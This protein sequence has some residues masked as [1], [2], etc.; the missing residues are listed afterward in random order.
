MARSRGPIGA[1]VDALVEA[2]T[3]ELVALAPSR[4]AAAL[5][6]DVGHDAAQLVGALIDADGLHT[7]DELTAYLAAL[8]PHVESLRDATPADLR[9]GALLAGK[10]AWLQTPSTL[11]DLLVAADA[12][13]ATTRS[14]TY[15]RHALELAHAVASIDLVP[16]EHELDAIDRYRTTLLQAMDR[17]GVRRPGAAA[18]AAAVP[19]PATPSPPV[20][21]TPTK[22]LDELLAE[23]DALVGLREVKAEV[24]RLADLLHVQAL[25]AQRGL[26]TVETSLHVVFA[27]NPGTGKTTVARLLGGIYARLGAVSKGHLVEVDRGGLVAGYVG[28]TA[29]R[30]RDVV[31]SA[32]GGVLL[33]DEAHALARGQEHDFGREAIDTLV[34]MMEDHRG[35]LAVVAAGYTQPMQELLDTNPGL[36][37]RFPKT[38]VFAD[39]TDDELVEI[40]RRMGEGTAYHPSEGAEGRLRELLAAAERGPS[41]G[42]ARWVRNVFEAAV[43]RH[44]SRV[45]VLAD[46]DIE[47]LSTLVADDVVAPG[48]PG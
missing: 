6:A 16:T 30:T 23:L 21:A 38:I 32:L 14:H 47:Q 20:T 33:I 43:S 34:K 36:R 8:G 25:R 28:Q 24:R 4:D 12:R 39:Y 1:Q 45:A 13:H 46:P 10:A 42:N 19:A 3:A 31:A 7:L 44:A 37:S 22:T 15:Y 29:T 2:V 5:R 11:A 9:G 18:P 41:F 17:A 35:D 27:G 48:H 26:P 40:F